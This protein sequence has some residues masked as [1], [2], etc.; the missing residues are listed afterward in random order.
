MGLLKERLCPTLIPQVEVDR[1]VSGI[2]SK[3]TSLVFPSA[4]YLFGSAAEGTMN[5]LSDF[6]LC[7]VFPSKE[8]LMESKSKIYSQRFSSFSI[9]WLFIDQVTF[10]R[11]KNL[12]GV[13]FDVFHYGRKIYP[14]DGALSI[15]TK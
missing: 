12:G 7:V 11:K 1:E 8:I 13:F 3:L 5:T 2:V 15:S 14:Y 4:I 10:D 6:D 9:D